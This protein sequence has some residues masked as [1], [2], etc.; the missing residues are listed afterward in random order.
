MRSVNA[1]KEPIVEPRQTLAM[2]VGQPVFERVVTMVSE[3]GSS[4][5]SFCGGL[6]VPM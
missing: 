1:L 6:L 3:D 5:T 4:F 2:N